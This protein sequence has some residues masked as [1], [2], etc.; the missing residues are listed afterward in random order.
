MKKVGMIFAALA[1]SCF[2]GVAQAQNWYAGGFG[3]M[4]YTHDGHANGTDLLEYDIGFGL[5]AMV[6]MAM[7]NGF[8]VEGEISYRANDVDTLNGV[9]Y[10]A[11]I[12][13]LAFMANAYYDFSAQSDMRPHLG[14]GLGMADATVEIAGVKYNDTVFAAQFIAGI[15]YKIAPD[16]AIV[17]DYRFFMTDELGLGGGAG[18]GGLEYA[19]S[20]VVAGLR[21][22]F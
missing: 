1:F 7:S 4:N 17:A 22:N 3:A 5:G 11:D 2:G 15:D 8:R 6:G 21:K 14:L 18:L 20:S 9:A 16:L 19:N 13:S 12:S 10:G